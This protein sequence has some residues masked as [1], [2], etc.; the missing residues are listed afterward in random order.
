MKKKVVFIFIT[1]C[2]VYSLG[3]T[4]DSIQKDLVARYNYI[5][6]CLDSTGSYPY[7]AAARERQ[8]RWE[9]G[10]D[11]I[12]NANLQFEKKL[13]YY[14]SHYPSTINYPFNKLKNLEYS[15]PHIVTSA[16]NN[17]RIYSWD[18]M[19]GG[20]ARFYDNVYQYKSEGKIHSC[21]SPELDADSEH[22]DMNEYDTIYSLPVKEKTFYLA[23]FYVRESS[24]DRVEGIWAFCIE[25]NDRLNDTVRLFKTDTTIDNFISYYYD[26]FAT[27][28]TLVGNNSTIYYDN[29]K[30]SIYVPVIVKDTNGELNC[31]SHNFTEYHFN[32]R[33]FEAVK[34][35]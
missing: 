10:H 11:S 33:Y 14:T 19:S 17:F 8:E 24:R 3:Q 26:L 6:N 34:K 32:G 15:P 35:D 22:F 16:D 7:N 4:N 20:T 1:A 2:S 13:L 21:E 30:R 29:K 25:K 28:D 12:A 9:N 23:K 31:L 27:T 5:M 18:N